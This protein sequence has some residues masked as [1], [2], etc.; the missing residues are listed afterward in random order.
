MKF[1]AMAAGAMLVAFGCGGGDDDVA[2]GQPEIPTGF[3]ADE[4]VAYFAA[5][6]DPD[7]PNTEIFTMTRASRDAEFAGGVELTELSSQWFDG[8]AVETNDGLKLYF[9]REDSPGIAIHAYSV[10]RETTDAPFSDL[11]LYAEFI[12]LSIAVSA[13]DDEIAYATIPSYTSSLSAVER[14][15]RTEDGL[16]R[17]ADT[18]AFSDDTFLEVGNPAFA[19]DGL[20]VYFTETSHE[21]SGTRHRVKVARRAST[22]EGFGVP[23]DFAPAIGDQSVVWE[24]PDS[25]RLYLNRDG[26]M[27]VL[28]REPT[29]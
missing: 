9:T 23:V 10:T 2:D 27:Y 14:A 24:S 26:A 19:G 20:S 22:A 1:S 16:F 11:R 4:L 25:C 13:N 7:V 12:I 5:Y 21:T 3:S 8:N 15:V 28:S 6:P 17:R 18:I 29:S